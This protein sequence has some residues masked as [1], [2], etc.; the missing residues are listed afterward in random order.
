MPKKPF[1]K[2]KLKVVIF[3]GYSNEVTYSHEMKFVLWIYSGHV[4]THQANNMQ[5]YASA[6]TEPEGCAVIGGCGV[7]KGEAVMPT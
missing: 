5:L 2:S 4:H 1:L 6:G 7:R 3:F